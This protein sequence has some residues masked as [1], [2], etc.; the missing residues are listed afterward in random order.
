M[1]R[2]I[3][4]TP[5]PGDLRLPAPLLA[6][7]DLGNAGMQFVEQKAWI[8]PTTSSTTSAP[9]ASRRADRPDHAFDHGAGADRRLGRSTSAVS[10]Y[11]AAFLILEGLMIGVF[12]AAGR[13]AVLR[14]S[15]VGM[16]IPMFIIIGVWGPRAAS[17]SV[18]SSVHLPRLGVHAGRAD[19][20]V[21]E[22]AA[23]GSWPTWLCC[24]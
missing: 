3:A 23:A 19:L 24:R 5:S 13:A 11:V 22:G 1:A 12:S 20:P 16:P 7:F 8:P 14:S 4:L 15:S 21:P 2:W 9:T 18:S 10:Q 17:T 6:G